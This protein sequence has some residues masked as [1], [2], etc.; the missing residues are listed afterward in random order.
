[1]ISF[2]STSL[3]I[4]KRILENNIWS[5]WYSV[6]RGAGELLNPNSDEEEAIERLKQR[7]A[8]LKKKDKGVVTEY[9]ITKVRQILIKEDLHHDQL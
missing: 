1:M 9:K 2:E 8:R 4:Y 5:G 3:R 7:I 6:T